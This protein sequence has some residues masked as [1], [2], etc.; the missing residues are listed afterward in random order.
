ME[1]DEKRRQ[2]WTGG[3]MFCAIPAAGTTDGI[4]GVPIASGPFSGVLLSVVLAT[5]VL[6]TWWLMRRW[7]SRPGPVVATVTAAAAPVGVM[8]ATGEAG[9]DRPVE[10][11]EPARV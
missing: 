7:S 3:P 4:T 1:S 9:S 10:E 5:L 8:R 6:G 11:R 2:G